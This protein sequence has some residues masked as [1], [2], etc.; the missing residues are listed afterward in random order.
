MQTHTERDV[1]AH[2]RRLEPFYAKPDEPWLSGP[3]KYPLKLLGFWSIQAFW[4]W[5]VLL[6]VTVSQ[7]AA[8]TAAMGA[9]GFAGAAAFVFF[10]AFEAGGK[11]HSICK[12]GCL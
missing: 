5:M 12:K 8:P 10:W 2:C 9:W 7:A 6:P 1:Y 4:E 11:P 3:S